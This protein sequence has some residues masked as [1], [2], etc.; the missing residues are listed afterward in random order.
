VVSEGTAPDEQ[1][2]TERGVTNDLQPQPYGWAPPIAV[3]G[4][5]L[6]LERLSPFLV[7][8]GSGYATT[9]HEPHPNAASPP[10]HPYS[11]GDTPMHTSAVDFD[12]AHLP[13]HTRSLSEGSHDPMNV[14]SHMPEPAGALRRQAS[15]QGAL[16][17]V[18][19]HSAISLF[20]KPRWLDEPVLLADDMG[21][22]CDMCFRLS[23][24]SYVVGREAWPE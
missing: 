12:N 6:M 14:P 2:P 18:C 16:L 11:W 4:S 15:N 10:H 8:A 24:R 23:Q 17:F 7:T 9:D 22:R 21:C 19:D 20:G 13:E 3:S 5:P 1:H